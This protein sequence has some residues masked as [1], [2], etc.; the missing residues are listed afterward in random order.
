MAVAVR[1]ATPKAPFPRRKPSADRWR[2]AVLATAVTSYLSSELCCDLHVNRG[3][4][5]WHATIVES[6][7]LIYCPCGILVS[8]A[9]NVHPAYN[10]S[11]ATSTEMLQLNNGPEKRGN[12]DYGRFNA[13]FKRVGGLNRKANLPSL[14][15]PSCSPPSLPSALACSREALA[16][17][18]R[19]FEETVST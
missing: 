7:S 15:S 9:T 1:R 14:T 12:A 10:C 11:T 6:G 2:T 17:P 5:V 16:L 3:L 19:G 13:A 8:M 18:S 4:G